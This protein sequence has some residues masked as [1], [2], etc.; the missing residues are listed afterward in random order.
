VK[1]LAKKKIFSRID[2]QAM[3]ALAKNV[4]GRPFLLW[5]L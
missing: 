5:K 2:L 1:A 4:L 3:C